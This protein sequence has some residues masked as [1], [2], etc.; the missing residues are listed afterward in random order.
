MK[1]IFEKI[2]YVSAELGR[3]QDVLKFTNKVHNM[4]TCDEKECDI[5]SLLTKLEDDIFNEE[6]SYDSRRI[7]FTE[8]CLSNISIF[9]AMFQ[10]HHKYK[11]HIER[12]ENL[13]ENPLSIMNRQ[14][15]RSEQ[16]TKLILEKYVIQKKNRFSCRES[17]FNKV[18]FT[19]L[20]WRFF[21][22]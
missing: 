17:I 3:L 9:N 10:L 21:T 7:K 12:I 2:F 22:F 14:M 1:V 5:K 13:I 18:I 6:L 16:L 4:D 20:K 19:T 15:E 8:L 11:K